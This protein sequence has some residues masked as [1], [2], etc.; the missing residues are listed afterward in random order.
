MAGELK[1]NEVSAPSTPA[2]GKDAIYVSNETLPRVRRI[3]SAGTVWPSAEIFTMSLASDYTLTDS[4]TAQKAFNATT[5]GAITLP[6]N[7]GYLLEAVYMITNTGTTTH[8]WA[9][10]FAGTASLTALDFVARG[11]SGITS[12]LTLTA[13]SSASQSNGA[14]ALPSTALV[15]T[16][17]STSTTENVLLTIHGTLRI[18]AAGTF[19]PQVKLSAGTGGTEKMLRGSYIRLTPIGA[20]TAT[21][22]GNWS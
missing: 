8:T 17:A 3:D 9:V 18:N 6:A 2:S 7:S 21:N 12:Q 11:R 20:D 19:I 1:L 5:N 14:G 15:M 10:L 13:D 16:A 22:L 4:A